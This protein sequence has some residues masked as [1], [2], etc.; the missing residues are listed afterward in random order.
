MYAN[1]RYMVIQR[2]MHIHPIKQI[3]LQQLSTLWFGTQRVKAVGVNE[4]A[5]SKY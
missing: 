2:A 5:K 3:C 4:L 1:A